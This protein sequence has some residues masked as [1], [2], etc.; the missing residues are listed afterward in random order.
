MSN[1]VETR[2][3]QIEF[4]DIQA[5]VKQQPPPLDFVLPGLLSGTVGALISPGGTGKSMFA[6]QAA[7][8][9]AGGPDTLNL[10]D[11]CDAWDL[12]SGPVVF[13]TAEDPEV[14]LHGRIHAVGQALDN[15]DGL[16]SVYETLRIAPLLG[17]GADLMSLDWRR[18]VEANTRGARL[19]VFDTLRRFHRL[20]EINGDDMAGIIRYMEHVCLENA[21]T[22]LFLHH[23]SKT[24]ALNRG[25]SQQASRGHSVLTDDARFQANLIGMTPEEATEYNL[26][27]RRRRFVRLAFPKTNYSAPIPDQWFSRR[28]GGVLERKTLEQNK[29]KGSRQGGRVHAYKG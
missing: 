2:L 1:E 21:T 19:L 3:E 18:W 7:I 16:S 17:L 8:T 10:A 29:C 12:T 25:D 11:M 13:L 28:S 26:E 9:V 20:D 22:V 14:V 27:N 6:L 4:L 23:T 5:L 15:G 24:G